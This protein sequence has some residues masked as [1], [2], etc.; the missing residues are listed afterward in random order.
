MIG[1]TWDKNTLIKALNDDDA[2]IALIFEIPGVPTPYA[3]PRKGKNGWYDLRGEEKVH[4]RWHLKSQYDQA[5]IRKPVEVGLVF[6]MPI[7]K[8]WLKRK[9]LAAERGVLEH[10]TKPDIDNL[11]KLYVDC[12]K[13]IV[14]WDDNQIVR[15]SP[16][17]K[18]TYSKKPKTIITVREI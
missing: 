11:V 3:A 1:T 18:K 4:I 12:L 9:R 17:P 2:F 8:S 15:L 13:K 7:P 6:E 14:I 10:T 16:S 5:P